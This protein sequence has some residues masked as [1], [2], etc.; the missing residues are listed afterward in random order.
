MT[1]W[2]N[3]WIAD[4]PAYWQGRGQRFSGKNMEN[5]I[6]VRLEDINGDVSLRILTR[7]PAWILFQRGITTS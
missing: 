5:L 4:K 6:G 1:C 2:R 3:G 7:T